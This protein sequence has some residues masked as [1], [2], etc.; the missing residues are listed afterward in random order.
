[1]INENTSLDLIKDFQAANLLNDKGYIE[2]DDED[3]SAQQKLESILSKY[4][5]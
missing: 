5:K 3:E 2:Y 1:M 4:G